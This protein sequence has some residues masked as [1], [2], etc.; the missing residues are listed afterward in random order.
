MEVFTETERYMD[1]VAG[2]AEDGIRLSL[3]A[4]GY[5]IDSWQRMIL[6]ADVLRQQGV[7]FIDENDKGLPPVLEFDYQIIF[8]GRDLDRPVNYAL[9]RIMPEEGVEISEEARPIIIIDPRAGHGPG[10]G[11]FKKESEVGIAMKNLHPVYFMIFSQFPVP[12]QTLADVTEAEI[13][14][15]EVVGRLHP[16]AEKPAVIGNCQAG[17]AVALLAADRPDITGPLF[18]NGS[19]LSYWAG[20]DIKNPMRYKGGLLGG[21]WTASMCADLGNGNFDGANIV[22]GFEDLNPANTI[23]GK[24]YNLYSNIDTEVERFLHFEKWWN[25]FF[26]MTSEEMKFITQDL[27]I[28]NR[29][30]TG[31]VSMNDGKTIDLKNLK[32]PIIVFASDGDNITPPQQALDWVRKV[33]GTTEEIRRSNQVIIY[34]LHQNIGH[35]GIFVSGKIVKREH[36]EMIGNVDLIKYL[37]PGLYEMFIDEEKTDENG[38]PYVRFE[39]REIEDLAAMGDEKGEDEF[40]YVSK[41]SEAY[42]EF[43]QNFIGPL[44]RS[45]SNEFTAE[46]F[47]RWHPLRL[48]RYI[49]SD[50]NPAMLPAAL[51]AP[52]IRKNRIRLS[53]DSLY[54]LVEKSLSECI[55]AELEY[56]GNMYDTL[57]YHL[58]YNL[59]DNSLLPLLFGRPER[60]KNIR[61]TTPPEIKY[62]KWRQKATEGGM[63]EG[64]IR[65]LVAVSH[66]KSMSD[67]SQLRFIR[68]LIEKA[69]VFIGMKKE[70]VHKLIREQGRILKAD[71]KYAISH[72]KEMIVLPEDRLVALELVRISLGE[73]APADDAALEL[74]KFFEE[75]L[76]DR[77]TL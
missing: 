46:L 8:D 6:F 4:W 60:K 16:K 76:N 72:I 24:K 17:W 21:I 29:L 9:A 69:P 22:K 61:E 20:K 73:P 50:L 37:P 55:N 43:Y 66:V 10:I 44:I 51:M 40:W 74:Q 11:G 15:I 52:G 30:E 71:F 34:L 1:S 3:D 19:P 68:D 63:V 23:W 49:L 45:F 67:K 5:W 35:L 33:W 18:L 54:R 27:F 31:E 36:N 12:G 41:V 13:S 32:E 56:C 48:E 77:K 58:F 38:A 53:S 14:F 28:G 26:F 25:G 7:N 64:L 57:Q 70:K 75:M 47:R 2:L 59:Y 42:E 62:R 65:A 39:K